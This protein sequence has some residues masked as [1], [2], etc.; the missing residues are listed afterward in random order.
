[1]ANSL[2]RRIRCFRTPDF[3]HLTPCESISI[4]TVFKTSKISFTE[5]GQF[6]GKTTETSAHGKEN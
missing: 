1:M 4:Q 6:L 3:S 5:I 2:I